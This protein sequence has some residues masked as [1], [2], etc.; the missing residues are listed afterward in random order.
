VLQATDP[1]YRLLGVEGLEVAELPAHNHLV[2]HRLG[3][4]LRPGKHSMTAD[5][6]SVFMEFADRQW[7]PELRNFTSSQSPILCIAAFGCLYPS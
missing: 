6:W 3:Y 1:V 7:R 2:G 4:Y 5:D